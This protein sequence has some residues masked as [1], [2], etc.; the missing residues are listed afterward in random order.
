MKCRQLKA[1]FLALFFVFVLPPF[2]L[3]SE[4]SKTYSLTEEEMETLTQNLLTVQIALT[5]STESLTDCRTQLE[6]L[7]TQ[8]ASQSDYLKKLKSDNKKTC[9]V[10]G[11]VSFSA[12]ALLALCACATK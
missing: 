1:F 6:T 4:N 2:S 5:Q 8:L 12:G 3:S 9:L 7:K 11:A 10:V